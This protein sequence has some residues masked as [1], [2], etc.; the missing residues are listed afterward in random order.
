MYRRTLLGGI[1]LLAVAATLLTA[2]PS[3][4]QVAARGV[5]PAP[6]ATGF[7]GTTF[8][9][10]PFGPPSMNSFNNVGTGFQPVLAPV[11][12]RGPAGSP[13]VV[14]NVPLANG[15]FLPT[16]FGGVGPFSNFNPN[17]NPGIFGV[18]GGYYVSP[19][20]M[21]SP[22]PNAYM[23]AST[24]PAYTVP[25]GAYSS[26]STAP[27]APPSGPAIIDV[28]VPDDAEVWIQG[29]KMKDKGL[30]RRFTTGVLDPASA[31]NYEVRARW[32]ER[33]EQVDLKQQLVVRAG[34]VTGV[35]FRK[36]ATARNSPRER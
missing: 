27:Q 11:F 20:A 22:Y 28:H 23:T 19:S 24:A 33:G 7:V 32:D 35:A 14:P 17:F 10:R 36:V 26:L 31:Y 2:G 3:V 8:V 4:A 30:T 13:V 25:T 6:G 21:I 1:A 15:G 29:E 12:A 16:P 18:I 34:D 5:G 9:P